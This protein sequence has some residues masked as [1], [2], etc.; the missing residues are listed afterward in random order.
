MGGRETGP[1]PLPEHLPDALGVPAGFRLHVARWQLQLCG[2]SGRQVRGCRQHVLAIQDA[3]EAVPLEGRC[4]GEPVR[5]L[6]GVGGCC[7]E[8]QAVHGRKSTQSG[9]SGK[10]A[11]GVCFMVANSVLQAVYGVLT[12]IEGLTAFDDMLK[13]TNIGPWYQAMKNLKAS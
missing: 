12:A 10:Q 4:Q 11:V 1:H 6:S 7:G 8:G 3:Q 9:G 13:N 5:V 2:A